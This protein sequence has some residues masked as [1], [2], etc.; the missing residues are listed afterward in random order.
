MGAEWSRAT[1]SAGK[2]AIKAALI[3]KCYDASINYDKMAAYYGFTENLTE[4]KKG[5]QEKQKE[6]AVDQPGTIPQNKNISS[7]DPETGNKK[8]DPANVPEKRKTGRP[9]KGLTKQYFKE[10]NAIKREFHQV[11]QPETFNDSII[12]RVMGEII[13]ENEINQF[14]ELYITTCDTILVNF[15]ESHP[16]YIKIHPYNYYKKILL[17][18]KRN[19][20]KITA[21]DIEK[22]FVVWDALKDLL[23]EIGLYITLETFET[24]TGIYK[25]QLEDRAKVS[26]RHAELCKK[27]YVERDTALI[28]ELSYNPYNQTNKI[29]LAKV[30]GI[31]EKTEPKQIEV[32]HDIR[33]YNALPM[34][35]GENE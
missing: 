30:H 24:V 15:M 2:A 11:Q 13:D 25:Y 16:E 33:N 1:T 4:I 19:T 20:P 34:F 12:E 17:E 8:K 28:N 5:F 32:H 23:N 27:I 3:L 14:K 6:F 9:N 35:R 22:C 10:R 18:I 7:L 26:P 21:D 31:V 29:F